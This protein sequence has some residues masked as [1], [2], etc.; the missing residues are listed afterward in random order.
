MK[1]IGSRHFPN[2]SIGLRSEP[3]RT[4]LRYGLIA[5]LVAL[6]SSF[7]LAPLLTTLVDDWSRR[8]VEMRSALVFNSLQESLADLLANKD[9]ARIQSLFDRV[10]S[11]PHI[12]AVA[13]C[14]G[15]GAPAFASKLMPASLSCEK[16]ARG[17]TQSFSLVLVNGRETLAASFPISTREMSGHLVLVNDLTFAI[18]RGAEARKYL[19]F[20]LG[21]IVLASGVLATA[22]VVFLIRHWLQSFR[23]A[24]ET[25]S[26]RGGSA[27][28][29]GLAVLDNDLRMA[30]RQMRVGR[31]YTDVENVE[32][33]KD[34]LRH[35]LATQ[36]PGVEVM[37][38]ANR[39]PYIHNQV[40]NEIEVQTPASG[41]VSALEPVMR[42]CGGTWIAHGS[43]TADRE[44]V[45]AND[46]LGVPP[47]S[48]EYTLRRVWVS[49]A[50][51][52]GYYYGLANEG[53]WPL[54]HIAF[55][56]PVFREA[57]WRIYQEINER[58]ASAVVAE[59][60]TPNP[61]VL[62]Q[63]YH[64]ALLP[65]MLRQRL[66]EATIIMFWHIPWP[67]SETFGIFPWKEDIIHGLLGSTIVG[68]H[69]Q[70]H[71]NNFLETVDRFVE[72]RI[73]RE[74]ES[75]TL[76]GH[77][78]F[79]RPYPISIAWPP[80]ALKNQHD[81]A[82]C[83]KV[84][85]DRLGLSQDCRIAVG[86]ERFDYTKGVLDR[87]RAVDCMLQAHPEWVGK[88]TLIQ[89][90]APTRSKLPTYKELQEE[91]VRVANEVNARYPDA[92]HPPITLIIRHHAPSEVFELFR[93]ADAC[94]VSSLHDGMNLVAKEFIAA[95]D[96]ELGVLLLSSFA[97]AS[98]ELREAL[99]INP[100]DASSMGE[101]LH[102]ALTMPPAEQRERMRL[103]REQVRTR[104]VYRWAG[105]MLRDASKM[106]KKQRIV[107]IAALRERAAG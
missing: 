57:D 78:T 106:R 69:T 105:Q 74:E 5:A 20:L 37:V 75:V 59:A 40:G 33:N 11:D 60:K 53:L 16:I 7:L 12:L 26:R 81:V 32:W 47:D 13:F 98:R 95:R 61:I 42:A 72:S 52:D 85:R 99:I 97:G 82:T 67:N 88:F 54:C 17:D 86:I 96:D 107:D 15:D 30:L 84:V 55:T 1:L 18:R 101:A 3:G 65:R 48:P 22:L 102:E 9:S 41:L 43:G 77:E 6:L 79:V 92:K 103:M 36:L 14:T 62:V 51:Q 83:R 58:F 27:P 94:I 71:C 10:S 39:E 63:D 87:M 68:F 76:R 31:A 23:R 25:A 90:A 46:R 34:A 73:D 2:W 38:V 21:G 8:D 56:R 35:I 49:D 45:D 80:A 4:I 93:A 29:V 50:E 19:A 104:N 89:A 66:P 64:F 24:V 44:T 28:S 70:F 100:Y 91:A